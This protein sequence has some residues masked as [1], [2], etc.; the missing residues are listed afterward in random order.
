MGAIREKGFIPWDDDIDLFM[1][2]KDY[3]KLVGEIS[4][5]MKKQY[6][7]IYRNNA[8]V[9]HLVDTS[10]PTKIK[11]ENI[12]SG[13][14]TDYFACIDL[15]PLDGAPDN[16]I[17][18]HILMSAIVICRYLNKLG[19][20]QASFEGRSKIRNAVISIAEALHTEKW[21]PAK[22]FEKLATSLA[23]KNCFDTSNWCMCA[24]GLYKHRDIYP[25]NWILPFSR[26]SFENC[27]IPVLNNW[28]GYL[29]QLY[30]DYITP[31][32]RGCSHFS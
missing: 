25:K 21:F 12:T 22:F 30:G 28:D 3:E 31:K 27:Q 13:H 9:Y 29:S 26:V 32:E 2:R 20:I 7:L 18:R 15:F 17:L 19:Y 10:F 5:K 1:P 14:G 8:C 23:M 16:K 6:K 11:S 24:F 4:G